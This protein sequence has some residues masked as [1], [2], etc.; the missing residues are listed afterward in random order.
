MLAEIDSYDRELLRLRMLLTGDHL[1]DEDLTREVLIYTIDLSCMDRV[2]MSEVF[3]SIFL[4][5]RREWSIE[6]YPGERDFHV[7]A[8]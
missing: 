8:N 6:R 4:E 2:F 5:Y 3:G 1:T 7:V